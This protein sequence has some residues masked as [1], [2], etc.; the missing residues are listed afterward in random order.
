MNTTEPTSPIAAST[1]TAHDYQ[2]IALDQG[3]TF[4]PE[5]YAAALATHTGMRDAL[6]RLRAAPLSFVEPV[7]EPASALRWIENGGVSA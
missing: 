4:Q 3:L 6:L 7:S 5:R 2:R 1:P